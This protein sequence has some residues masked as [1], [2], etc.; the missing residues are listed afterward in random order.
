M[1]GVVLYTYENQQFRNFYE[2]LREQNIKI[3][4]FAKIDTINDIELLFDTDEEFYIDITSLIQLLRKNDDSIYSVEKFLYSLEGSN[5][6][7][8]IN[9]QYADEAL[10]ILKYIFTLKK[11]VTGFSKK[12]VEDNSDSSINNTIRKICDL[13]LNERK[14]LYKEFNNQLI[15]HAKFKEDFVEKIE[16]FVIVNKIGEQKILS[17]FLLGQSGIGKTEVARILHQLLTNGRKLI[18]VNFGNYGS[19]D[20]LNSLIGSPRGY[21]GSESG[22]LNEKL[23]KSDTGIILVDEF[24][25]ADSRVFNFFLELLEDGKYTDSLGEVHDLNAYII[26]FTSNLNS[27][28]FNQLIFPELRSRIDYICEFESLNYNEKELYKECRLKELIIKYN[29][30]FNKEHNFKD[31]SKILDIDVRKYTNIRDL[32]K[33]ITKEFIEYIRSIKDNE[34]II[35]IDNKIS[36]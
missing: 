11:E 22:E 18:K 15:G 2:Y 19:K 25:K 32:N 13:N 24:E 30:F 8:V 14:E 29:K 31:I 7:I 3:I 16:E 6:K 35:T 10:E 26:I 20:A 12:E 23:K 1:E 36:V 33:R 9:E 17:L 4:S 34:D 5:I 28:N 27:H 21:M